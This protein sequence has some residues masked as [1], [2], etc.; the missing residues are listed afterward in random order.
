MMKK[1]FWS[2]SVIDGDAKLDLAFYDVID[3]HCKK[4]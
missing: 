1:T 3:K 4:S 2:C